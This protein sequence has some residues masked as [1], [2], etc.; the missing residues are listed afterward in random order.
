M[1]SRVQGGA[2]MHVTTVRSRLTPCNLGL[3]SRRSG[4]E[5]EEVQGPII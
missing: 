4:T 1:G 5:L 2:T 3:I